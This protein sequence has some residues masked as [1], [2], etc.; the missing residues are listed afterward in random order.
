MARQGIP[1][2]LRHAILVRDGHRCC[3]CGQDE[4]DG[5]TKLHID[6]II[7]VS[8]DGTNDV[9]NLQTLCAACNHGKS[10]TLLNDF[11]LLAHRQK[12][13]QRIIRTRYNAASDTEGWENI[14]EVTELAPILNFRFEIFKKDRFRCCNCNRGIRDGVKLL[15][16]HR[17]KTLQTLC[18]DCNNGKSDILFLLLNYAKQR[19]V[20]QWLQEVEE[21]QKD[22]EKRE[23]QQWWE[24]R[25]RQYKIYAAY[26][27][28]KQKEVAEKWEKIKEFVSNNLPYILIVIVTALVLSVLTYLASVVF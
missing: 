5:I 16:D 7:P 14:D 28:A 12:Q 19:R 9:D 20:C 11:S 2:K 10:S 24:K 8:H 3:A 23:W 6:H 27:E 26:W 25:E 17:K 4:S 15:V 22:I 18:Q 21:R 1:K 13:V